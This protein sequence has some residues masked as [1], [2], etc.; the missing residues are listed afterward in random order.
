M[1]VSERGGRR[2]APSVPRQ[3]IRVRQIPRQHFALLRGHLDGIALPQLAERYLEPDQVGHAR[4]ILAQVRRNVLGVLEAEGARG[5]ARGLVPR[6]AAP[7]PA[8][9][10]ASTP[11][12]EP[13]EPAS[14]RP[15]LDEFAAA[16][17]PDGVRG[18]HDLVQAYADAYPSQSARS[19]V[20]EDA[21]LS[22]TPAQASFTREGPRR[23]GP[24]KVL[25]WLEQRA[26][27]EPLPADPLREWIVSPVAE[28]LAAA[29]LATLEDLRARVAG[30]RPGCRWWHSVPG[31][32]DAT[33]R[34]LGA[35][36]RT[37]AWAPRAADRPSVVPLE[38]AQPPDLSWIADRD[39]LKHWLDA[40]GAGRGGRSGSGSGGLAVHTRRAYFQQ[41]ERLILWSWLE[42]GKGLSF[43]GDAD[44]EVYL[45]FLAKP[46][47]A[48][49][50][51]RSEPRSSSRW[52]PLEGPLSA[53]SVRQSR[54]VL[55]AWFDWAAAEQRV[56]TNP[57]R[58]LDRLPVGK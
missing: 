19:S 36:A 14:L 50:A 2:Y 24:R 41:G 52:R 23:E 6:I 28:R 55:S 3:P 12:V 47:P 21:P 15:S 13:P 20:P 11:P 49:C 40:K 39:L 46:P 30:A 31:V 32:G 33:G 54:V 37:L 35:W 53:A 25:Y 27:R 45:A 7:L 58:G 43:L 56:A 44:C 10:A 26:V 9:S 42:H 51:P 22:A 34:R 5:M 8:R 48:W 57:F 38:R 29:G 1:G 18:E 4:K 16:Y 17:D